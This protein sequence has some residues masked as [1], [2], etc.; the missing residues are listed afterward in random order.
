MRV[1]SRQ[2]SPK[3]EARRLC[4]VREDLQ[5]TAVNHIDGVVAVVKLRSTPALGEHTFIGVVEEVELKVKQSLPRLVPLPSAV[6]SSSASASTFSGSDPKKRKRVSGA[7]EKVFNIGA[8]EQLDDEI[9][10]MFYTGDLSFHFVRNLYYVN[11]FKSA[12]SNP[13]PGYL[14][15]SYNP[16]KTTL[17]Q[18]EKANIERLLNPIKDSWMVKSVS[19]CSDGW[20]DSQRRPLINI[21]VV[22]EIGLMFLKAVNCEGEF[23][24]KHF[25]ANLLTDS[26]RE[27]GQQNVVQVITG[28]TANCKAPGLL[29][30]AKFPHI[31][32]TPCVVHTLNLALKNICSP[33]AHPKYDDVMEVYGWNPKERRQL[34]DA[35]RFFDVVY[36]ILVDRWTKNNTP[37]HC[38]AHSLS[39]RYYSKQWL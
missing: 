27:M 28:N 14:P 33:S 3:H 12:C 4:L 26:I 17:L 24:D 16:L 32:W 10:R 5:R 8:S 9:A 21:M 36:G 6:G 30:E 7:I 19:V 38:L 11:A 2:P 34:N 23:K 31:F 37:L 18:K 20:L 22:C 29:V 25:I 35:S 39:P 15:P 1:D 13:I